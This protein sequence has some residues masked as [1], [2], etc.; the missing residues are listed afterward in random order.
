MVELPPTGQRI[1]RLTPV[2]QVFAR[3]DA[4]VQ[5]VLPQTIATAGALGRVLAK[6]VTVSAPIPAHP[7]SL[8]DGWAVRSELVVDAGPYAPVLLDPAPPWVAAGEP[9]LDAADAVLPPEGVEIHAG[10]AQAVASIA[11]GEGVLPAGGDA[12]PG[13]AL[14]RAGQPLRGVDLAVLATLGVSAVV[15]RL[16][17]LRLAPGSALFDRADDTRIPLLRRVIEADGGLVDA[18]PASLDQ[19]L[20][21]RDRLADALR[22]DGADAVI[23]VGGVGMGRCEFGLETLARVGNVALHGIGLKPG[24]NA[25]LGSV[26][27][28]PVLL[29]P[30][31]PDA[32]LAVYLVVG[33]R[34]MARLTAR[35]AQPVGSAIVA[36]KI[37][38]RKIVSTVGMAQVVLVQHRQ[39][40]IEPIAAE[41]FALH[42]MAQA[43]GYV[44]VP[45]ASEGYAAG[46]VVEMW[47]LP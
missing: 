34:L 13:E 15:V 9:L 38:V 41:H 19:D 36:R 27:N 1:V 11:P 42:A 20:D 16:P 4:L 40:G 45:P 10:A 44:V 29:L 43:D 35:A 39:D 7:R 6:D 21:P 8:R 12:R 26:G 5:P 37:L 31:E 22:G 33:R 14:R 24:A 32:A 30:G 47:P 2:E 18:H 46:S 17:R 28:R 23:V 25:A 3:L